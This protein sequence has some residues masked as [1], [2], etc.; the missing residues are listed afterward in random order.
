MC[1]EPSN[2]TAGGGACPFRFRCVGCDHFRTDISYLPDLHAY[3]DDLLATRER[4][5]ASAELD[6]WARTDAMPSS[7][8]ITK[9][10]RLIDR[11]RGG[12]DQLT[13]HDRAQID[14][15]VAVV[16]QHRT[17]TAGSLP[18]IRQPLPVFRPEP[19]D[20]R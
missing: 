2:V 9:V 15:A 1:A 17:A 3:L 5:A 7:E 8:E 12:L 11:V 14:H 13:D 20:V 6:S 10:R 4:L 16:R 18:R 19:T